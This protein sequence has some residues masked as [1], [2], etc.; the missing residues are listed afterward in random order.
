MAN[1]V[2][3]GIE[4]QL[5]DESFYGSSG[6]GTVPLI[7]LATASNKPTPVATVSHQEHYL[8]TLVNYI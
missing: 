8:K 4:I 7:I 5:I 3:P 1:L 2:S 6:P